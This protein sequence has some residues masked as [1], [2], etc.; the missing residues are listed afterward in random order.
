MT[1]RERA[2]E[3]REVEQQRSVVQR[4]IEPLAKAAID[5]RRRQVEESWR[6]LNISEPPK[7]RHRGKRIRGNRIKCSHCAGIFTYGGPALLKPGEQWC[8]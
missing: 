7:I 2:V 6:E 4:Q 5:A 3:E 8:S 1:D